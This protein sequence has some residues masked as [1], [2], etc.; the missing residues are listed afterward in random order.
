MKQHLKH[1]LVLT[2]AA[3]AIMLPG[4]RAKADEVDV[5]RATCADFMSMSSNDQSQLT[6]WLAGYYAGSAQRPMLDAAKIMAAPAALT[7]ICAK[8][9]QTQLLGAETRAVFLPAPTP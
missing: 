5:M 8:A 1:I 3:A 4:A 2:T 6:L 7:A 9:P